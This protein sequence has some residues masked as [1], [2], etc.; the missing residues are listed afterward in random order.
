M[1]KMVIK[2][3]Q[4]DQGEFERATGVL[5]DGGDVF[6]RVVADRRAAGVRCSAG[7]RAVGSAGARARA[8]GVVPYIGA[9]GPRHAILFEERGGKGL[10]AMYDGGGFRRLSR[11]STTDGMVVAY[12]LRGGRRIMTDGCLLYCAD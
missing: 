4:C 9:R 1:S 7:A 11:P 2:S 12:V 6:L 10:L 8:I 3:M 5:M